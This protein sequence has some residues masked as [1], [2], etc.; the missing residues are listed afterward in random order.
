M[1]LYYKI[2]TLDFSNGLIGKSEIFKD[3]TSDI[4]LF[5]LMEYLTFLNIRIN[6]YIISSDGIL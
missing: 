5:D 2:Y 3:V 1:C 6:K 4:K